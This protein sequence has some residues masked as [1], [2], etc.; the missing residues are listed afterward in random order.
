MIGTVMTRSTLDEE[1][2]EVLR[3]LAEGLPVESVARRL[4]VSERTVRRRTRSICDRLEVNA[5]IQAIVWAAQRG[6]L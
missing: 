3:L 4:A 6:L 2:I 1:D 5:P